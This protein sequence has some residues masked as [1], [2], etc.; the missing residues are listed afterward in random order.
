[1]VTNGYRDSENFGQWLSELKKLI[2]TPL[3]AVFNMIQL[4][5]RL[6]ESFLVWAFGGTVLRGMWKASNP[7]NHLANFSESLY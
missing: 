3:E 1:L 6:R 5:K 4:M 2:H 7:R